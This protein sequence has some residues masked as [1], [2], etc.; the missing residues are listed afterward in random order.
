MTP[1]QMRAY[2]AALELQLGMKPRAAR[3]PSEAKQLKAADKAR[4]A[5]FK[6]EAFKRARLHVSLNR[7]CRY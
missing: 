1:E 5:Q 2:I 4:R 7:Y 6:L 3:K